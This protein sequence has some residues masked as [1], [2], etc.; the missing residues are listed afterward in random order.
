MDLFFVY[1]LIV[2][3]S[4]HGITF[5]LSCEGAYFYI[6][7]ENNYIY[8]LHVVPLDPLIMA[9]LQGQ[10]SPTTGRF[11]FLESGNADQMMVCIPN[12]IQ[13][14][15]FE[16]ETETFSFKPHLEPQ[17]SYFLSAENKVI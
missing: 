7:P 9:F 12:K 2:L 3:C 16:D 1:D 17:S 5:L 4:E 8:F 10:P 14:C 13:D 15:S 6:L 11:S